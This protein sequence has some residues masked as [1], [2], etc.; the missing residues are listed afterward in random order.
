MGA[1]DQQQTPQPGAGPAGNV[2]EVLPGPKGGPRAGLRGLGYEAQVAKLSPNASPA[3]T[4]GGAGAA[5]TP[6][7][8]ADPNA[9][10]TARLLFEKGAAAF[11]QGQFMVAADYFAQSDQHQHH[12]ETNFSHAQALRKAGGHAAEAVALYQRYLTELPGG[13][14][15]KDAAEGITELKGPAPTGDVAQD[16]GAAKTLFEKGSKAFDAGQ[17]QVAADL[18]AQSDKLSPRPQTAFSRA[19]ALRMAGGRSAEAIALYQRYL[20]ELPGGPRAKEAAEHRAKLEGPAKTGDEKLDRGAAKTLFE[21][22]AAAF[23]KGQYLVA[24]DLMAQ[25]DKLLPRAEIAFSRAQA[26]R[27]AG[28]HTQEAITLY[29]RYVAELPNGPRAKESRDFIAELTNPGAVALK[30]AKNAA[31]QSTFQKGAAAFELKQYMVAADFFAQADAQEHH[32]EISFSHAQALRLAGGHAQEAIA[33]YQRYVAELPTG[34]RAKEAQGFIVELKG[35]DKSGDEKLDVGNAK[36]LFQKGEKAFDAGQF[37][38]AAD[39]MAQADT[40]SP[41]PQLAFSRAQALRLAGGHAAEAIALYQRYL[42]EL[43]TGPRAEESQQYIIELKGPAKTGNE[44]VDR[45][46]AKA[47]F[48]KGSKAYDAGQF[49]VAADLMGQ[50]DVLAPRAALAFSRAQALR[51][52]GGHI[53]EAVSLYERYL[54]EAP[55]GGRAAE[56]K[57]YLDELK[58]PKLSAVIH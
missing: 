23:D 3:A 26:L 30:E 19:Q 27:K 56:S 2:P 33:L 51:R 8:A 52:A 17:F 54:A 58:G 24:A 41:R 11:E 7:P 39:L 45:G 1:F 36:A 16:T 35:P 48:E 40:L 20:D 6:A 29:Q 9:R 5:A 31:S 47:L 57:Q 13:P 49:M 32:A 38:V 50:A 42:V 22:G 18:M 10:T 25:A 12:A 21:E 28:G 14:R 34:P 43:P 44:A 4:Q 15:A 55:T 46:E 53:P 37:M